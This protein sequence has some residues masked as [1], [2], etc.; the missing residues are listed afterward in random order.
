[1]TACCLE[2]HVPSSGRVVLGIH[3]HRDAIQCKQWP[4]YMPAAAA[5]AAALR[6]RDVC[7]TFFHYRTIGAERRD[8]LLS[9]R[10]P[11]AATCFRFMFHAAHTPR[12][13]VY[14]GCS[15]K[16]KPPT[17]IHSQLR[18]MLIDIQSSSVSRIGGK[19]GEH[20]LLKIPSHRKHAT[21]YRNN[22]ND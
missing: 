18:R 12:D 16:S 8:N 20:S 13:A 15:R 7:G 4:V 3:D 6:W 9:D 21:K 19:L 14:T 11:G 10:T 1:M 22:F 5:V 17:F 2:G